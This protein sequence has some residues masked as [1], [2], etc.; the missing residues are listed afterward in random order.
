MTK[1]VIDWTQQPSKDYR[2]AEA[3]KNDT[4]KCYDG[5]CIRNNCGGWGCIREIMKNLGLI[6]QKRWGLLNY[7]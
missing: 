6:M 1:L 5:W 7:I 3:L 4:D 2:W